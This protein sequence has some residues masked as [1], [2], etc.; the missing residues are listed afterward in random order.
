MTG[1]IVADATS[2]TNQLVQSVNIDVRAVVRKA[3]TI[4]PFEQ[5]A[6]VVSTGL[7]GA[8]IRTADPIFT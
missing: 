8:A 6:T 3:G 7:S 5:D 1:S 2:E 4:L